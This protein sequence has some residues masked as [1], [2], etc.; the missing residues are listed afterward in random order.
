MML[1]S[2][3]C[4]AALLLV[5]AQ[6]DAFRPYSH[7]RA[8]LG[9]TTNTQHTHTHTESTRFKLATLRG[10]YLNDASVS[11]LV[12]G[13]SILWLKIWTTVA[14]EGLLDSKITRK[15][16]HSGS[17][18]LFMAHWPLY[19]AAPGARLFAAMI[20]LLQVCIEHNVLYQGLW[21][22]HLYHPPILSI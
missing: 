12:L 7:S 21:H 13:E 1:A 8:G 11:V 19:S 3:L 6:I 5:L 22:L 10:G 15:I 9:L 17:A 4:L 14:K 20:P 18:P 16:I 2:R